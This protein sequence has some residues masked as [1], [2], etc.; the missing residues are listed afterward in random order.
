MRQSQK[1][2]EESINQLRQWLKPGDTVNCILR[3]VSRSGMQREICPMFFNGNNDPRYPAYHV[4]RALGWRYGKR[5]GVIVDGCG[6]D[7]GFHLVYSIGRILF[8][9]GFGIEGKGPH[10]HTVRPKTPEKATEAVA[11]GYQFCGRNG[12]TSGWDNDG[13]Y[14]L[15]HRW[16]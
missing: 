7:M 12:D 13:G 16:L 2:R 5:D 11:K 15:R 6:M 1:E 9:E 8:P 4:A 3:H 10:G 14:A